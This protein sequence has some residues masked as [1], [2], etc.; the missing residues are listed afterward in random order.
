MN[1][2]EGSK[3]RLTMAYIAVSEV[4]LV[5][6]VYGRCQKAIAFL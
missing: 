6:T 4:K 1:L 3:T 2:E 5:M